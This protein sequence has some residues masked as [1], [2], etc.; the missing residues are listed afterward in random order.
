MFAKWHVVNGIKCQGNVEKSVAECFVSLDFPFLRGKA[1]KTPYGNYTPDFDC[2]DFFIE[3]KT[4]HSWLQSLGVVGLLENAKKE[5]FSKKS[6]NSQ[7]KM[8]WTDENIKPLYVFVQLKNDSKK[9]KELVE[10]AHSLKKI[11][12][13]I[14]DLSAFVRKTMY[15]SVN[16]T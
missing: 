12:G 9:F 14:E 8:Q 10:P 6:N 13:S 2:G 4:L 7:L 11:S 16:I 15:N 5:E 1:I 3:V